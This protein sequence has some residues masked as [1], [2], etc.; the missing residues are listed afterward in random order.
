M[1]SQRTATGPPTTIRGRCRAELFEQ[2]AAIRAA[3]ANGV[4]SAPSLN[5]LLD[6][7]AAL[8]E[9]VQLVRADDFSPLSD[10]DGDGAVALTDDEGNLAVPE[11]AGA[12]CCCG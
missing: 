12:S 5:A 1:P 3:V 7:I 11:V 4:G 6:T 10:Y 9:R 8:F 2:L